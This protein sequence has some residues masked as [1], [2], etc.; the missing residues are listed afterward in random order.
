MWDGIYH[1]AI[2]YKHA[3]KTWAYTN[4][5]VKQECFVQMDYGHQECHPVCQQHCW[6]TIPVSKFSN[7]YSI[8]VQNTS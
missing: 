7:I 8:P 2:H 4:Y 6:Q 1:T 3:A 5:L